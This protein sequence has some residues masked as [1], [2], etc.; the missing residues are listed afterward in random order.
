MTFKKLTD[1]DREEI[2]TKLHLIQIE[3]EEIRLSLIQYTPEALKQAEEVF[4]E[5]EPLGEPPF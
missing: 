5:P 1:E 2:S 4:K 3:L